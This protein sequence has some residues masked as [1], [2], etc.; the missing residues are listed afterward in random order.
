MQMGDD[1]C[2]VVEKK[3]RREEDGWRVRECTDEDNDQ[4]EKTRFWG[5]LALMRSSETSWG[6][7]ETQETRACSEWELQHAIFDRRAGSNRG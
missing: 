4:G 3:R 7:A 2:G 6:G 5:A 1:L